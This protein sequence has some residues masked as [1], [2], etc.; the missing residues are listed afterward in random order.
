MEVTNFNFLNIVQTVSIFNY[1]ETLSD[2]LFRESYLKAEDKLKPIPIVNAVFDYLSVETNQ[3]TNDLY[4]DKRIYLIREIIRGSDLYG[5]EDHEIIDENFVRVF[6]NEIIVALVFHGKFTNIYGFLAEIIRKSN[7]TTVDGL[8]QTIQLTLLDANF[9]D[10]NLEA[11][12]SKLTSLSIFHILRDIIFPLFPKRDSKMDI[13]SVDYIYAQAGLTF[14]RSVGISS[15]TKLSSVETDDG[16]KKNSKNHNNS[17][18]NNN[19]KDNANDDNDANDANDDNA[20]DANDDN[21]A[22]DANADNADDDNDANDANANNADDDNDD[23]TGVSDD[24]FNQYIAIGQALEI[25]G[26]SEKINKS[27]LTVFA[28][29][30]LLNYVFKE[31]EKIKSLTTDNI[32]NNSTLGMKAYEMLFTY[33]NKT[34]TEVEEARND[35]YRYQFYLG[36][37]NFKNRTTLAREMIRSECPMVEEENLEQEVLRYKNNP[38]DY[39]CRTQESMGKKLEDLNH[40][41]QQEVNKISEKYL[42]YERESIRDAFGP[43]LIGKL[44]ADNVEITRGLIVNNYFGT[45]GLSTSESQMVRDADDLFRFYFPGD[46]TTV[47]YALV[48]RDNDLFLV[49]ESDGVVGCEESTGSVGTPNGRNSNSVSTIANNCS[50][51]SL[52]NAAP[53]DPLTSLNKAVGSCEIFPKNTALNDPLTSPNNAASNGTLTSPNDTASSDSLIS[54]NNATATCATSSNNAAPNDPLTSPNNSAS[55]GA[56]TSPNNSASN[57]TLTSPNNSASDVPASTTPNIS[58]TESTLIKCNPDS[59][60]EKLDLSRFQNFQE[61]YFRDVI[62]S[63]GENFETLINKIAVERTKNFNHS[64]LEKGYDQT[65]REWWTEFGL[66]LIP[67]HTCINEFKTENFKSAELTCSLDTLF[68]LPFLGEVGIFIQKFAKIASRSTLFAAEKTLVS[69]GLRS[70]IRQ[71]LLT[72]SVGFSQLF[73]EETFKTLGLSFLRSVDPGFELIFTIGKKGLGTIG[74]LIKALRYSK[75]FKILKEMLV[76]CE[77]ILTNSVRKIDTIDNEDV[78]VKT[79]STKGNSGY[80]YKFIYLPPNHQLVELRKV[81]EYKNEIPVVFDSE[82]KNFQ[83]INIFTGKIKKKHLHLKYERI[84]ELRWEENQN[85]NFHCKF[86]GRRKR[87]PRKCTR[88]ELLADKRQHETNAIKL[89]LSANLIKEHVVAEL[90]KYSLVD[91]KTPELFVTEWIKTGEPPNWANEYKIAEIEIFHELKFNERIDSKITEDEAQKKIHL[92]NTL[93]DSDSNKLLTAE[94]LTEDFNDRHI[95]RQMKFEDFYALRDYAGSGYRQMTT[96]SDR[97]NR[98]KNAF[99]RLALRQSY[100]EAKNYETFLFRGEVRRESEIHELLYNEKEEYILTRFTA[101]S[102]DI[103]IAK[104]FTEL[105]SKGNDELKRVLY[106]IYFPEPFPKVDVKY[107]TG[108]P[109]REVILLP[110]MKFRVKSVKKLKDDNSMNAELLRVKLEYTRTFT[111]FEWEKIIM[112]EIGKLKETKTVFYVD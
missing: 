10:G 91:E 6:F 4:S 34:F 64:L 92:L 48:R 69:L 40:I 20:D 87:S 19:D 30:A 11:S 72:E 82:G 93:S 7:E 39:E 36:L 86:S 81:H 74:T 17:N 28:L 84:E 112:A 49:Q 77:R 98:I 108:L 111:N 29:P 52:E 109:E 75:N 13:L 90:S 59:F 44:D 101:T 42:K 56:L 73:T 85:S 32:V 58:P 95:N 78:Y 99:Y 26:A 51:A 60:R 33:L 38:K 88:T 14:L 70:A 61:H 105:N 15:L 94:H 22:N 53:N 102:E 21:D 106:E 66:S 23:S 5:G 43:E 100:D 110:G 50:G 27:A 31:K 16:N 54:S 76:E 1:L 3:I 104:M 47:Y 24:E 62:K 83:A 89:A 55:N 8:C 25:L 46:E 97:T 57:G 96:I 107:L 103:Q 79:M 68:M 80:G 35:D 2:I 67:F 37:S 12:Y 18:D 71:T 65:S 63:K 45:M 41:Y 9:P